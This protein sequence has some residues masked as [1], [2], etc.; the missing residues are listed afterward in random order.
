MERRVET[1]CAYSCCLTNHF[2]QTQTHLPPTTTLK[3]PTMSAA[4][5]PNRW[6]N[7]KQFAAEILTP[8]FLFFVQRP[9]GQAGIDR[10]MSLV[11]GAVVS[12]LVGIVG[13]LL[14]N[15]VIYTIQWSILGIGTLTSMHLLIMVGGAIS[16]FIYG[17]T[18]VPVGWRAIAL[19]LGK[20]YE[21]WGE[22]ENGWYWMLWPI[23]SIHTVDTRKEVE[24][25]EDIKPGFMSADNVL[26]GLIGSLP[27]RIVNLFVY[28]TTKEDEARQFVVGKVLAAAREVI[29]TL[30]YKKAYKMSR[31]ELAQMIWARAEALIQAAANSD[32]PLMD[33]LHDWGMDIGRLMIDNIVILDDELVK[34]LAS[35]P[36]EIEQRASQIYQAQTMKL[37][38]AEL[39]EVPEW[40][41]AMMQVADGKPVDYSY[42][43]QVTDFN[44]SLGGESPVSEGLA[45]EVHGIVRGLTTLVPQVQRGNNR[46][47]KKRRKNRSQG[48]GGGTPPATP[49]TNPNP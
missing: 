43:H 12:V 40:K 20:P 13:D 30:K 25:L 44:L 37:A 32:A 31:E 34:A 49:P 2:S 24:K 38:T 46:P 41:L 36:V 5:Q 6:E 22:L 18:N 39:G 8:L 16:Y 17:L 10:T 4:A 45:R 1:P 26:M 11:V 3:E 35:K 42:D 7:F 23:F 14:L 21:P 28:V 48:G 29:G 19:Y 27:L 47:Q 33:I 15:V 9:E